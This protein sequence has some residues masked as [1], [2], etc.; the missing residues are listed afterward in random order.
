MSN[1]KLIVVDD[2]PFMRNG[3]REALKLQSNLTVLAEA[4]TGAEAV[5]MARDL[6]PDLVLMDFYM[7]EMSGAEATRHI[8]LTLPTTKVIILSADTSGSCV[9]EAL[10]AGAHG[11][12][13]KTGAVG[14][15]VSAISQVMD[16]KLYLSPEASAGI[17]DDY[18]KGLIHGGRPPRPCH[19]E[20]DTQLLRLVAQGRRSKEIAGE[21]AFT[22]KA[23]ETH[24][25]RLMKRFNCSNTAEL[26]CY[27]IREGIATP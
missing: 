18:R 13:S 12:L 8:K 5:K 22:T 14:E 24:R 9:N 23:V 15:L 26:V 16:G 3:L 19:N 6:N 17:L 2:H 4:A 20:R 7:P 10:Q 21:L 1:V 25:S 11:Y 27:A